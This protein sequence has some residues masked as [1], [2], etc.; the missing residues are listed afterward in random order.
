MGKTQGIPENEVVE[1]DASPNGRL[2][3]NH[4]LNSNSLWFACFASHETLDN[5]LEGHPKPNQIIFVEDYG[6]GKEAYVLGQM[7]GCSQA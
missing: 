1:L 6:W 4:K 2:N 7:G 5:K 3:K